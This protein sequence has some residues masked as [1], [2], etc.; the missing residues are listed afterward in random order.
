MIR[1]ISDTW[2]FDWMTEWDEVWDP[3][4][5]GRWKTCGEHSPQANVFFE[6]AMVRAWVDTYRNLRDIRPRFL[7]ASRNPN[8]LVFLP[9]IHDRG[10]WKDAWHRSIAPV[11]HCEFD[12][13]DPITCGSL[14]AREWGEFWGAFRKELFA[15]WRGTFDSVDLGRQRKPP[16]PEA[17]RVDSAPVLDLSAY[18]SLSDV[19]AGKKHRHLRQNTR[20]AHRKLEG[21]GDVR[22]RGFAPSEVPPALD[23]LGRFAAEHAKRWPDAATPRRFHENLVRWC[24]PEGLLRPTELTVSGLPIS[25]WICL[26]H[27]GRLVMYLH[28]WIQAWEDYSPGRVHLAEVMQWAIGEGISTVDFGRGLE[29]YKLEWTNEALPL[30]TLAWKADGLAPAARRLWRNRLRPYVVS[31]KR[32]LTPRQRIDETTCLPECLL[33]S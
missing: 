32:A 8:R 33:R 9:L 1:G 4:F 17:P 2:Q 30:H 12:Y 14:D 6:P 21:R 22:L 20:Q 11:G 24:L 27:R 7:V 15:R 28:A 31:A 26:Q 25:W 29:P 16:Q 18:R 10:R 19:W 3:A 23:S 13:H 5:V